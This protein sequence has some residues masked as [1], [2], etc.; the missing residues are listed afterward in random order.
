MTMNEYCSL[1]T[2]SNLNLET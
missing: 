1:A 2:G